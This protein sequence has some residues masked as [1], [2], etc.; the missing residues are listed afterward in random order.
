MPNGPTSP[1]SPAGL[2]TRE[3]G[4]VEAEGAR[5]GG[6]SRE[7]QVLQLSVWSNEFS[8]RRVNNS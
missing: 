5:L 8:V 4:K 2:G 7:N 1:S 6:I 3:G